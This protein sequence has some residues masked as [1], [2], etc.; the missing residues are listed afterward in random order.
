MVSDMRETMS[1][2]ITIFSDSVG[3]T[4]GKCFPKWTFYK[5]TFY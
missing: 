2:T 3:N 5:S 4:Y 1:V